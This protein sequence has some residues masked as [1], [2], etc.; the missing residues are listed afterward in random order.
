MKKMKLDIDA[1]TVESFD[2]YAGGK[3]RAQPGGTVR[4]HDTD[5]GGEEIRPTELDGYTCNNY[6]TCQ[7]G[8]ETFGGERTCNNFYCNT[9]AP[10]AG[11]DPE[12]TWWQYTCW[13]PVNPPYETACA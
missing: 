2:V 9:Q 7:W 3:V 13:E 5:A 4:G 11:C 6:M 10:N 12:N 1:L 8:C